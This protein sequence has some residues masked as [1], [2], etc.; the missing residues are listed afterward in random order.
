VEL[1]QEDRD[2]LEPLLQKTQDFVDEELVP[3]LRNTMK[4]TTGADAYM[5][6]ATVFSEVAAA[7]LEEAE[8]RGN[9]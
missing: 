4:I 5:M 9:E 2:R 3:L 8:R 6:I 7:A 1:T